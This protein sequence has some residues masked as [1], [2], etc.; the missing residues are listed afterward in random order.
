VTIDA[1]G[2]FMTIRA[3]IARSLGQ[4]SML[5]HKKGAVIAHHAGSAM[6]VLAFI[7]LGVFVVSVVGPGE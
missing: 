2:L 6:A 1:E 7:Q 3:I 5:L 4:Q